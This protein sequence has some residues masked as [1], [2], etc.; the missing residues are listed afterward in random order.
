[1]VKRELLKRVKLQNWVSKDNESEV[2]KT[3]FRAYVT[4]FT[5]TE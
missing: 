5:E 2:A 4:F 1:M 3:V